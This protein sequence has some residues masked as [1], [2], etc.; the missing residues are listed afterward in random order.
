ML[1]LRKSADPEQPLAQAGAGAAR[2]RTGGRRTSLNIMTTHLGC[3]AARVF[4][5][6]S[7]YKF[8]GAVNISRDYLN[9]SRDFLNILR[10]FSKAR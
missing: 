9:F 2:R 5:A 6:K 3:C 7:W 4:F 10:S 1:H 8:R